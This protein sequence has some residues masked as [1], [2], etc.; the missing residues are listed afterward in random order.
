M[1]RFL[2]PLAAVIAVA[3]SLTAFAAGNLT[4]GLIAPAVAQAGPP[5]GPPGPGGPNNQRFGK[6]LL[7]L[8]PPLT[9]DQKTRI[10]AIVADFRARGKA[11]TDGQAK[12]DNFRAMIVKVQTVLTPVQQAKMRAQQAKF[13][14]QH[15]GNAPNS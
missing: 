6:M 1:K 10:R 14:S 4:L 15:G 8:Q 11:L 12:R 5:G 13:R 2:L 3:L 9:E 7:S